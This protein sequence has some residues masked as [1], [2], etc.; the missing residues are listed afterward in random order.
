MRGVKRANGWLGQVQ[1]QRFPATLIFQLTLGA[2]GQSC[3]APVARTGASLDGEFSAPGEIEMPSTQ[4]P[5]PPYEGGESAPDGRAENGM[6]A[7]GCV[8][9][10][11]AR[12]D[13][14]TTSDFASR[15]PIKFPPSEVGTG[16]GSWS[17][18]DPPRSI[19]L[20]ELRTSNIALALSSVT[21]ARQ[22]PS[23]RPSARRQSR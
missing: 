22:C 9:A 13:F 3:N 23:G 4:P 7:E 10:K 1:R 21:R 19:L 18:T 12:N 20:T 17:T 14:D 6:A 8:A 16:G 11:R 15:R 5:Y 2:F